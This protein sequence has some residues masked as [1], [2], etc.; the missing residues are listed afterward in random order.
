MPGVY[1]KDPVAEKLRKRE[2][3][4]FTLSLEEAGGGA[5]LLLTLT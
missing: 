3:K 1:D 2:S 4:G 5:I